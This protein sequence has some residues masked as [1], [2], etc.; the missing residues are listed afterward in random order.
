MRSNGNFGTSHPRHCFKGGGRAGGGGGG[1]AAQQQPA[2]RQA[3]VPGA[4]GDKPLI[5]RLTR[6]LGQ[7]DVAR[8][9]EARSR[10]SPTQ[11]TE[12]AR[13]LR[14]LA[15][16]RDRLGTI[17]TAANRRRA[18]ERIA[19]LETQSRIFFPQ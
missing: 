13:T 14:D 4:Y 16:T 17:K 15:E 7:A 2:A 6:N 10:L 9:N 18:E 8:L 3:A 19:R 12:A 5:P 1:G 11:M